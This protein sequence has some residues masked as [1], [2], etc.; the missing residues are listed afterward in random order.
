MKLTAKKAV[1]T[2]KTAPPKNQSD[3]KKSSL[4]K[5]YRALRLKIDVNQQEFW[6]RLGMTQSC[7]SRYENGRKPPIYVSVMAYLIYI[8]G[9]DIDCRDFK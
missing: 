1:P 3:T 8:K 2:K 4:I 9:M 6:G 7:G 5:D